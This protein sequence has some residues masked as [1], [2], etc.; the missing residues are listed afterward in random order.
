ML[1]NPTPSRIKTLVKDRI[2]QVLVDGQL[3]E[4]D[5]TLSDINKISESFI[6]I[7]NGI[8]HQRIDYPEPAIKENNGKKRL[9][10]ALIDNRQKG[11]MID[12]QRV[13]RALRNIMENLDCLDK[14]ISLLFVDDDSIREI[15]KKYLSRDYP[16]NVISFSLKEG[17]FGDINPDLLGDI[18]ISVETALRDALKAE[19]KF[20]EELDYLIIH[21][22]LHLLGYDH[23]RSEAEAK[24]MTEKERELFFALNNYLID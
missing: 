18:I 1:T 13:R 2:A 21:G 19:I 16:T 8:F 23:E 10:A 20:E 9:M 7:L 5:L 4:C 14:E 12:F 3:D 24:R 6:R 22:I 11:I 17:D 15:N